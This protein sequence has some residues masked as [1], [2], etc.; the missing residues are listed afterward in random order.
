MP[1]PVYAYRNI[2][3]QMKDSQVDR[4]IEGD[5]RF[6]MCFW[7]VTQI[8]THGG[9]F[10]GPEG[11]SL[12]PSACLAEP[13]ISNRSSAVLRALTQLGKLTEFRNPRDSKRQ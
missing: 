12:T 1:I 9:G 5:N 4:Q 7:T 2:K 8:C 11:I 13:V 10:A 3:R 6:A